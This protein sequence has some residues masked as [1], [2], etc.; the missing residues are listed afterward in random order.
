MIFPGEYVELALAPKFD[1]GGEAQG[2]TRKGGEPTNQG[3][4][5]PSGHDVFL[6]GY[7]A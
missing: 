6:P 2:S 4:I 5:Q 3:G 7:P 1:S